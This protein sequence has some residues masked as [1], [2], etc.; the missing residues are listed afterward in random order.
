MAMRKSSG[1]MAMVNAKRSKK[2]NRKKPMPKKKP[3]R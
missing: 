2:L 3:R 1:F